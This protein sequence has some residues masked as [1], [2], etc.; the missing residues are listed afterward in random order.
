MSAADLKQMVQKSARLTLSNQQLVGIA[1]KPDYDED[2]GDKFMAESLAEAQKE[3]DA[4]HGKSV[5]LQGQIKALEEESTVTVPKMDNLSVSRKVA[6]DKE[7]N[8]LVKEAL[9]SRS[10]VNFNGDDVS[11]TVNADDKE[12]NDY[13]NDRKQAIHNAL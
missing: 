5:D 12:R 4:A 7:A 3:V 2:D 1:G 10:S 11:I 8:D 9:E 13:A 6:V